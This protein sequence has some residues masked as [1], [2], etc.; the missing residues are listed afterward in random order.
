MDKHVHR[1]AS[2]QKN[3]RLNLCSV[4]CSTERESFPDPPRTYTIFL[5]RIQ[6]IV[7]AGS[8]YYPILNKLLYE[9]GQHLL[10]IQYLS[11]VHED[12]PKI[13]NFQIFKFRTRL[14]GHIV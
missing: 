11:Y 1:G 10:D 13:T 7:V 2:L 3:V 5:I 6:V 9:F 4:R 8:G 12:L 14:D